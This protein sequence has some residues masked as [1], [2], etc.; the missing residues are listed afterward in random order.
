LKFFAPLRLCVKAGEKVI[1]KIFDELPGPGGEDRVKN[2]GLNPAQS[3]AGLLCSQCAPWGEH[4][5]AILSKLCHH[6]FITQKKG[7]I[8][9]NSEDP[10]RPS[11]D[12]AQSVAGAEGKILHHQDPNAPSDKSPATNLPP[13]IARH[14][15]PATTATAYESSCRVKSN[16]GGAADGA[17]G[18]R[19]PSSPRIGIELSPAV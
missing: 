4:P 10:I 5:I 12:A 6:H 14:K 11:E 1:H 8:V 3:D 7:L 16:T 18:T 19:R 13:Q 17:D 15:L 9:M 2:A